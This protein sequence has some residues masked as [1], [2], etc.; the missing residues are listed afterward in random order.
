LAKRIGFRAKIEIIDIPQAGITDAAKA[1]T[2]ESAKF[3]KKIDKKSFVI[4][5]DEHGKLFDS[6]EFSQDLQKNL[7]NHGEIVFVIG[8]AHGLDKEILNRANQKI[9][10]GKMVWTRNL[11][12]HMALE[13]IYRA[14][15][16][17]G[18]S[19]FHKV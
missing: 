13:Q 5:C 10:F 14:L 6:V 8:G 18:G 15:E 9:S 2:E 3:L 16:I 11:V 17:A 7:E 12:R 4:A 1:K 19:N